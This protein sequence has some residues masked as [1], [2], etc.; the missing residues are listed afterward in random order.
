MTIEE[1]FNNIPLENINYHYWNR[2]KKFIIKLSNRE[3]ELNGY[4][5]RHH[6]IPRC[7]NKDLEKD[8]SNIINL[9]AREHFI[10]HIILR[11]C[12]D[13]GI[14]RSKLVCAMLGMCNLRMKYHKDRQS[15]KI[16]SYIYSKLR[17]EYSKIRKQKT[18]GKT[19]FDSTGIASANKGCICITNDEYNRYIK[20]TEQIPEG[21]H[22]GC[23]QPYHMGKNVRAKLKEAWKQ[24]GDKRRGKNHANYGKHIKPM[25]KGYKRI[26][27]GLKNTSVPKDELD[28]Y[29]KLGWKLGMLPGTT[30]KS[31][32]KIAVHN[33]NE[34]IY[35]LPNELNEYL[36][37]GYKRGNPNIDQKGNKNNSFNTKLMNNGVK[38]KRVS[39]DEVDQYLKNGWIIG[40][41]KM[42]K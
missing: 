1:L 6:I 21:W 28:K 2:Y 40:Q 37:K 22:K 8:P 38:N 23:T 9:T 15:V 39:L 32:G 25:T 11:K 17:E 24:N 4:I 31:K 36:L 13:S 19:F 35:I 10:A 26:N 16:N 34:C 30:N 3:Y 42:V 33:D 27:N 29:L 18:G 5:E 12:Y 7:V 20:P 41:I 14:H